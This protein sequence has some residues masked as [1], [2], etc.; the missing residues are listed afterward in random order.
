V[1]FDISID[2]FGTG[3]SSLSYL[4]RFRLDE[5]KVDRSFVDGIESDESDRAIVEATL[6]MAHRLGMRVVAEGV[7]TPAQQAFLRD[8]GCELLQGYLF[9][10]P[11]APEAFASLATCLVDGSHH[12]GARP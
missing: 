5:L 11:V 7:E 12:G 9:S 6:A 8:K 3:Y 4:K 10:K 2:D 1:G